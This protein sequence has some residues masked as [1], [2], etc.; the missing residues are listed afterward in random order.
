MLEPPDERSQ[1]VTLLSHTMNGC[2]ESRFEHPRSS[3]EVRINILE[4]SITH[5]RPRELR[6]KP[7]IAFGVFPSE[8]LINLP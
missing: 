5:Y 3:T 4:L 7:S 8:P 2:R 6:Y 1:D